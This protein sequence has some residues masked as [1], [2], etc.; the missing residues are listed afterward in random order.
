[1]VIKVNSQLAN[2]MLFR[3]AMMEGVSLEISSEIEGF[4]IE[5]EGEEDIVGSDRREFHM[6]IR[7]I[8]RGARRRP[9]EE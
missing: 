2:P 5:Q 4:I 6:A 3:V 7:E 1:M 8:M 9:E